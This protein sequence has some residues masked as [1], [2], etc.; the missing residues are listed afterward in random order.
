M[1]G[2]VGMDEIGYAELCCLIDYLELADP[3]MKIGELLERY[4]EHRDVLKR[5]EADWKG[6]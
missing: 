5:F 6:I 3:S 2:R 1:C 4:K